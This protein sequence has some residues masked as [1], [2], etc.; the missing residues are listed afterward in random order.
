M[1]FFASME[2]EPDMVFSIS[3]TWRLEILLTRSQ[4]LRV[5]LHDFIVVL[6]LFRMHHVAFVTS[7]K[8][9]RLRLHVATRRDPLKVPKLLL[10]FFRQSKID[11]QFARVG[12]SR[13]GAEHDCIN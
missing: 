3:C 13:L 6:V 11:E 10:S 12:M 8:S 4:N 1:P 7:K 9:S 5:E 2:N